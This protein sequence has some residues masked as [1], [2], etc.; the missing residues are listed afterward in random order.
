MTI[1][2]NHRSLYVSGYAVA[3]FNGTKFLCTTE[4]KCDAFLLMQG[5]LKE[6]FSGNKLEWFCHQD[7]TAHRNLIKAILCDLATS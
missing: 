6:V 4:N 1:V 2:C 3:S 5:F 7:V